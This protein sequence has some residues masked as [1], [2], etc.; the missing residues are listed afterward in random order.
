MERLD[1]TPGRIV[2]VL[3]CKGELRV[4]SDHALQNAYEVVTRD[5]PLQDSSLDIEPIAVTVRCNA[6]GFQGSPELLSDPSFHFAIPI[7]SC[8]RCGAEVDLLTGRELYIGR[9][10]VE[11]P[12]D[13]PVSAEAEP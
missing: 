3:L 4:L 9:L 2:R 1:N 13:G 7:L 11:P 8:P 10:T 5:T 6:C 12:P